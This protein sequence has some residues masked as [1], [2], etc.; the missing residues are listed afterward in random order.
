MEQLP[1][2]VNT[3]EHKWLRVDTTINLSMQNK[4]QAIAENIVNQHALDNNVS[5][6]GMIT[7]SPSGEIKT[8]LGGIDYDLSQFNHVTLA[9]RQP[10]SAFKTFVVIEALSRGYK[11]NHIL[12]DS[13]LVIKDWEPQNFN[14]QFH[15]NVTLRQAFIQSFNIPHI[16]LMQELG[17]GSVLS[18]AKDMGISSPLRRDLS[19][20]LGTSEVTL[21]ELTTAYAVIKNQGHLVF[22]FGITK[23]I[24]E[25]G[26]VLYQRK[27]S[28]K[29]K[30]L[31]ND[32]V[33]QEIDSLLKAVV[34]DP[35]GTGKAAKLPNDIAA[36][37]TG[38]SQDF[39]DAWF[40]GYDNKYI[41]G[42]WL[43]N[44]DRTPMENVTGG[45]LPAMIWQ[46]TM[47]GY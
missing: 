6:L 11:T 47:V 4:A 43:G 24:D 45:T 8:M 31:L 33:V 20:T 27:G 42:V 16:R 38:T 7:M 3:K 36:G 10:G 25:N 1:Y 21:L 13:P 22:P 41:T 39:R 26:N 35:S 19:T 5:Q 14:N 29:T 15:G 40:I 2:Y 30:M 17:I 28:A 34:N 44:D 32:T 23:V 9:K 37:K 46:E 18:R 12:N